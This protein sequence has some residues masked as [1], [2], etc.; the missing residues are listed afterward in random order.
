M[1][2]KVKNRACRRKPG[3]KGPTNTRYF[4]AMS[5]RTLRENIFEQTK[6]IFYSILAGEGE[7]DQFQKRLCE[8]S[9]VP[10]FG[11]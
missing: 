6:I 9:G 1:A 10:D 8:V 2:K 4:F 3:Q 7:M 11:P 5:D